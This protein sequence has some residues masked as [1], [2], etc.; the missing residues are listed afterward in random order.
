[1]INSIKGSKASV[2]LQG[3]NMTAPIVNKKKPLGKGAHIVIHPNLEESGKLGLVFSF[4]RMN[5]PTIGHQKLVDRIASV[6]ESSKYDSAVFLSHSQDKKKNPLSYADKIMIAKEAFGGIVKETATKTIIELLKSLQSRYHNLIM[7]VGADRVQEFESLLN[8]YNGKDYNFEQIQVVS[9]GDRDPDSDDPT[10]KT[11]ASA[12]RAFASAGDFDSFKA[13]LP[14]KLHIHAQDV[15]DMVRGGMKLTEDVQLEEFVLNFAQRQKRAMVMRKYERKIEA[16]RERMKKRVADNSHLIGRARKKAIELLRK[17]VA[18]E[19][20]VNY[21]KLS[22]AEKAEIDKRVQ[23]RAAAIPKIMAKLLPKVRQAEMQRVA[24]MSMKTEANHM[25]FY[26]DGRPRFDRRFKI[27]KHI[28]KD[29]KFGVDKEE[30]KKVEESAVNVLFD[31]VTQH[32]LSFKVVESL[33]TKSQSSGIPLEEVYSF[34][35][36]GLMERVDPFT[37]VNAS[38]ANRLNAVKD[39]RPAVVS[40]PDTNDSPNATAKHTAA[41][42]IRARTHEIQRKIIEHA[43]FDSTPELVKNYK[44]QTPFAGKQKK[45]NEDFEA[46]FEAPADVNQYRKDVAHIN[47]VDSR[48]HSWSETLTGLMTKHGFATIGQGK[49]ASVFSHD[50]YPWIVK[51]F[52]KDSA[53]LKWISF[54]M[55]HQDNP[56]VPKIKGKVIKV[57]PMIYSIRL[58][59]LTAS[60]SA[61]GDAF[62]PAFRKWQSDHEYRSGD[63][64]ID[65]I[66][67]FFVPNKKLLDLH[68]ENVMARGNQLVVIDPFYN[69]FDPS[70]KSYTIGTDDIN[71]DVFGK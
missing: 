39:T 45:V 66:L 29:P 8:K 32:D 52:M 16:A 65:E 43:G 1:M 54:A 49:Y 48:D 57:T 11:S 58:E 44:K 2:D 19:K 10:V 15:Y 70:T 60:H 37:E 24:A 40:P 30:P 41:S 28:V 61:T 9:A 5:P 63:K 56:Y 53:Y 38:I 3:D 35:V 22:P 31:M 27:W 62:L 55:K 46:L 42:L 7:V 18:G 64:H 21:D 26:A 50:N 12:M 69:W 17:K 23:A 4:G 33:V 13:G 71:P 25:A 14:A 34:Y 59:K 67:D 6:A 20:G 68:G 47:V 51:V 36:K